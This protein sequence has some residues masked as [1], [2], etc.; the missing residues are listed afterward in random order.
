MPTQSIPKPK[1]LS[2][3]PPYQR[4]RPGQVDNVA[5]AVL[6]LARELWVVTDRL[7]I[8]EAV[9][10]EK[11]VVVADLIDSYQPDAALEAKLKT[12]RERLVKVIEDSLIGE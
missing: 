9:L 1:L 5:E 8:V 2:D 3:P 4:M 10:E 7:A 6:A 11:G 12:K